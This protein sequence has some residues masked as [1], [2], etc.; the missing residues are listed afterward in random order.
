MG[1]SFGVALVITNDCIIKS[2]HQ[3]IRVGVYDGNKAGFALSDIDAKAGRH[4]GGIESFLSF[5]A[6]S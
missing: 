3:A 1:Q 6:S 5:L 4:A 2:G